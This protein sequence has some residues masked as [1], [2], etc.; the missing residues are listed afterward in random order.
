MKKTIYASIIAVG[1]IASMSSHATLITG[2]TYDDI[3]VGVTDTFI[4]E[5]VMNGSSSTYDET[6]WVNEQLAT[7]GIIFTL[8]DETTPYYTTNDA[9]GTIYAFK[10]Y[11]A[12]DYFLVKNS[13]NVALFRNLADVDWGV[14]DVGDLSLNFNIPSTGFTISHVSEFSGGTSV[15][16]IPQSIPEPMPLALLGLGLVGVGVT[17]KLKK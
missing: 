9:S 2:G 14:F 16:D 12:S 4:A 5:G 11:K 10:L 15:L 6:A 17:R 3:D 13:T 7:T 8:K 1:L